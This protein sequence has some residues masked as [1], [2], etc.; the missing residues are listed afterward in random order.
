MLKEYL[1]ILVSLF[2]TV[3]VFFRRKISRFGALVFPEILQQGQLQPS[4]K[5]LYIDRKNIRGERF[6][7]R[8]LLCVII[9]M[10]SVGL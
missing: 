10:Y 3:L 1:R 9:Q 2:L 5:S 7:D 8:L 6:L 4:L